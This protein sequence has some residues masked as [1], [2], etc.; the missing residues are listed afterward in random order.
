[1]KPVAAFVMCIWLIVCA[2]AVADG[3][4]LLAAA[5]AALAMCAGYRIVA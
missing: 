4:V 1:M 5:S 3:H 2:D